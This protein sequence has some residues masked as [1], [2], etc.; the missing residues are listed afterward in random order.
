MRRK[1]VDASR[2]KGSGQRRRIMGQGSASAKDP[3]LAL[4]DAPIGLTLSRDQKWIFVTIPYGLLILPRDASMIERRIELPHPHPVV[5]EAADHLLWIGGH[6]L[7]RVHAFSGKPQKF[8]SK[9]A[10]YVDQI[11]WLEADNRLFGVGTHGEILIDLEREET[12]FRRQQSRAA[13]TAVVAYEKEQCVFSEAK[14]CAMIFDP[15]YTEGYT[16]LNFKTQSDWENPDHAITQVFPHS[17]TRLILAAADGGVAWTGP[18]ARIEKEYFPKTPQTKSGTATSAPY[19]PLAVTSDERYIYVL[20]ERGVLH[21]FLFAQPPATTTET[22][23][24]YGARKVQADPLPEAQRCRL[25]RPASAMTLIPGGSEEGSTASTLVFGGPKADGYLGQCWRVEMDQLEWEGLSTSARPL[26]Q[27]P[28]EAAQGSPDFTPTKHKFEGSK[29]KESLKVDEVINAKPGQWILS[30]GTSNLLERPIRVLD[31]PQNLRP[32]DTL[33]LAAMFRTAQGQARP[34]AIIWPGQRSDSEHPEKSLAIRVLIWGDDPRGWIE[35]DTPS[36][37][38]QRW[39]R[40]ELFPLQIA[41]AKAA[42]EIQ[43]SIRPAIPARWID[44]DLFSAL[45]QECRHK[46]EVLW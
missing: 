36:L 24:K 6:H 42:P 20:R 39:N 11:Q 32:A 28:P 19:F 41:L 34:G 33:V 30:A 8:G 9:L 23:G 16:Q 3:T 27:A 12:L 38:A 21:R 10:G 35:V 18:S 26:P 14:R 13:A 46:L 44:P 25:G 29:L 22:R 37:R 4:E 43:D 2:N 31:D 15:S 5:S 1:V 17:E 45:G 7:F 40:E